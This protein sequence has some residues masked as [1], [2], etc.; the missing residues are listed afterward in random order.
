MRQSLKW[1]VKH[2]GYTITL[3]TMACSTITPGALH[4]SLVND[5]VSFIN[6]LRAK[7]FQVDTMESIEQPFLQA[8]GTTLRLSGNNLKEPIELQSFNYDDKDLGTD[9]LKAAAEDASQIDPSGNPRT[10][11]INWIAPPHFFHKERIIVIYLG[12]DTNALA[13][14]TQLLGAQFA[15]K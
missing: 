4:A 13:L 2:A 8:T 6:A 7:G 9:G 3:L 1:L 12:N 14:F 10:A 15:G 5:Q 11:Q